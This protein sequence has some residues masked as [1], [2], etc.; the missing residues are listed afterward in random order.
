M[1]PKTTSKQRDFLWNCEGGRDIREFVKKR[2]AVKARNCYQE[3]KGEI[4]GLWCDD[5]EGTAPTSEIH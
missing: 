3:A 5:R 1:K 4:E 2:R